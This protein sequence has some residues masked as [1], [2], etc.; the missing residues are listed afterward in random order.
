MRILPVSVEIVRK[1]KPV[2]AQRQV[3]EISLPTIH[4]NIM[5]TKFSK[6]TNNKY[7]SAPWR[8]EGR[9]NKE[10]FS[11]NFKTYKSEAKRESQSVTDSQGVIIFIERLFCAIGKIL[12]LS[13]FVEQFHFNC[14]QSLFGSY[15]LPAIHGNFAIKRINIP[16]CLYN[17]CHIM[18][19]YS[20]VINSCFHCYY[21]SVYNYFLCL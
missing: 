10:R 14:R 18:F 2:L 4:K 20:N 9:I 8:R 21:F 11:L 19:Q 12:F 16:D 3:S 7:G 17:N 1:T 15:S 6:A 13:Y 5:R